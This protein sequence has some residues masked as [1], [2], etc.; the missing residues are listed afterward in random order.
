MHLHL[1]ASG[2][3]LAEP[4]DCTTFSVVVDPELD[5]ETV[6]AL[7]AEY[8]AGTLTEDAK[9]VF[10]P[11]EAL[12]ALAGGR[13]GAD[14]ASRFEKMLAYAATKGWISENGDVRGHIDNG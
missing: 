11:P 5:T 8:K 9:Y 10:V 6:R 2:P 13:T 1:T 14:W 3:E 7:L 12:R 4:D